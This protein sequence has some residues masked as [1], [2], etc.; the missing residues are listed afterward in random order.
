MSIT[1]PICKIDAA[2]QMGYYRGGTFFGLPPSH[3]TF[4]LGQSWTVPT[5][6]ERFGRT[7][8]QRGA[9]IGRISFLPQRSGRR[10]PDAGDLAQQRSD[11]CSHQH[12]Y[13][14]GWRCSNLVAVA[15]TEGSKDPSE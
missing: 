1:F 10:F 9:P 2:E 13:R 5:V 11:L 12:Y 7:L 14:C 3:E 15:F 6:T 8:N 4:F